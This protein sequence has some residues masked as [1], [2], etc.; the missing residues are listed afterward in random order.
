MI[1]NSAEAEALY[2]SILAEIEA[3][4]T[5]PQWMD[6][7]PPEVMRKWLHQKDR[8]TACLREQ[9]A[10]LILQHTSPSPLVICRPR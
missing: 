1:W 8:A 5:P 6:I 2:T 7:A 9:A 4:K 10:S 3:T